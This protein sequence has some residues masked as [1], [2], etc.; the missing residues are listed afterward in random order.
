[1]NFVYADDAGDIGAFGAGVAPQVEGHDIQ[2][3]LPG[4]GSADVTG[5][6]PFDDLPHVLNPESGF[7]VSSNQREVSADYPYQYTTSYNFPDQGY[8]AAAIAHRLAQPGKLTAE[9]MRKLQTDYTD[10]LGQQLQPY[11]LKAMA[12]QTL[13]EPERRALQ[14]LSTWDGTA[15]LDSVAAELMNNFADHLVYVV[16]APWFAKFAVP[17]DPN[18]RMKLKPFDAPAIP[19]YTLQST[20]LGWL[21]QPT[22]SPYLTPPGAAAR[23]NDAVLRQTFRETVAYLRDKYGP[24][25]A[26]WAFG[27]HHGVVFQ[28]LLQSEPLDVGPF[29][30]GGNGRTP[31]AASSALHRGDKRIAE[32][33]VGGASYRLVVDWGTGTARS[34]YPGGQSE[35][36]LSPWY[37]NG[38]PL[39]RNGELW[40]MYFG[41]A[42]LKQAQDPI[43]WRLN[44]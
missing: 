7:V 35:S 19:D 3:P 8:R 27:K 13:D 10:V 21:R 22:V 20:L 38:V 11:V 28:S 42:D 41:T 32:I 31:N 12:G 37:A 26:A 23:D 17:V 9:D 4:D 18:G 25:P 44:R 16:F 5:T 39:W 30:V 29:P 36:P 24:D 15:Q 43:V 34:V 40:P 2:L 6:I 1:M 14:A 33:T